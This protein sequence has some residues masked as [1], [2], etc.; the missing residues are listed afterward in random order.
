MNNIREAVASVNNEFRQQILNSGIAKN[1]FTIDQYTRYLQMQYHLVKDV[2]KQFYQI[3]SHPNIF[4]K[5][6]FR[7]FLIEFGTEEGPHFRMAERD[8]KNLDYGI[9]ESPL[10]VKLWWCYFDKVVQ[11]KP[12][13]RLGGTCILENIGSA[14]GDLVDAAISKTPFLNKGNTTFLV[15]HKHEVVNH[16]DL[17]LDEL[18]KANLSDDELVDVRGGLDECRPMVLRIFHWVLYGEESI[19]RID[20]DSTA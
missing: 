11:E 2:Q 3:A 19:P 8:L 13:M 1:G 14:V 12:L 16:G 15:L 7:N 5:N 6:G 9:G 18:E 20:H 17:I 10:D 4:P